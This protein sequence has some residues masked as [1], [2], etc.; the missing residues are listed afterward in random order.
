MVDL[1]GQHMYD[2]VPRLVLRCYQALFAVARGDCQDVSS[3][4]HARKTTLPPIIMEVENSP[5][6]D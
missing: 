1:F 2:W 6:G 4:E 5:F 3:L